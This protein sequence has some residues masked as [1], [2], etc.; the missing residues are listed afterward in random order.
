MT[1]FDRWV[2]R[3]LDRVSVSLPTGPGRPET[4]DVVSA[5]RRL[6]F[7]AFLSLLAAKKFG[8]GGGGDLGQS[9]LHK[10][11]E[12]IAKRPELAAEGVTADDV[13]RA[14]TAVFVHGASPK[15]AMADPKLRSAVFHAAIDELAKRTNVPVTAQQ[16]EQALSLLAT[17]ELFRDLASALGAVAFAVRELPIDLAHDVVHLPKHLLPL[18]VAVTRDLEGTPFSATVVV[19]D[20]L[21]D[22]KLDHPPAVL[23]HTMRE[24]LEIA[25]LGTTLRMI[26]N[27]IAP[28]NQSVRLALVIY[29]RANDIPLE[30]KDLDLLRKDLLDTPN[31][32]L[33]PLLAE[34]VNRFIQERG[35]DTALEALRGLGLTRA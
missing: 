26:S 18:T 22:G 3:A 15:Q 35:A 29:A 2:S 28:E 20:L 11:A 24:L 8:P 31:P 25:T 6:P 5:L 33:G 23:T 10:A 7:P 32:D 21:A 17:G 14:L 16:A 34:A 27:L 30:D 9:L 13:E 1:E 19:Q 12:E 4:R